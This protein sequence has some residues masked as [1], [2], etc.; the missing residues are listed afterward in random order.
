[1]KFAAADFTLTGVEMVSHSINTC[2]ISNENDFVSQLFWL[3][4]EVETRAVIIYN[5]L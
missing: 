2:R 1:M 4:V 3:Q 5:E